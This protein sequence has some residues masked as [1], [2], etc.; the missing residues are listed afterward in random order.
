MKWFLVSL[1]VLLSGC[2]T[3][4]APVKH[5]LPDL[6]PA[7]SEKCAELKLLSK[8][9]EKLSEFLKIVIQNY[10]LYHECGARHDMLVKWYNEQKHIH[11]AVFNKK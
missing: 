11:D 10:T 5:S 2:A 8:D 3:V 1:I 4:T 7:L 9:E 6:P